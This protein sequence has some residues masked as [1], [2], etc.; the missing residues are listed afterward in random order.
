MYASLSTEMQLAQFSDILLELVFKT[1]E[2][3]VDLAGIEETVLEHVT[4]TRELVLLISAPH[5]PLLLPTAALQSFLDRLYTLCPADPLY[6]FT[7]LFERP[8]RHFAHSHTLNVPTTP[9]SSSS[10][11]S[12]TP[13]PIKYATTA[14]G[15]TFDHLHP[16]H[17][18]LLTIAT[19]LTTTRIIVGITAESLL[20][21]KKYARHLESIERRTQ[22]VHD[23][24]KSINPRLHIQTPPINVSNYFNRILY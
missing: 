7:V 17:K 3:L 18:I 20:V 15:G 16:G 9:T 5:S 21:N 11:L 14:L 23:F 19:A 6:D 8:K 24:V 12:T 22:A 10:L 2:D 4:R 1:T 13:P